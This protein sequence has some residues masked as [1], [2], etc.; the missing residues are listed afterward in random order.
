[1]SF[2]DEG[3]FSNAFEAIESI[4]GDLALSGASVEDIVI[5]AKHV[6]YGTVHGSRDTANLTAFAKEFV[7]NPR[8][9]RRSEHHALADIDSRVAD[10]QMIERALSIGKIVT[11]ESQHEQGE[12]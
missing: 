7:D 4:G 10:R 8:F 6:S 3:H 11:T 2:I 9:V 12:S 1:M 5:A